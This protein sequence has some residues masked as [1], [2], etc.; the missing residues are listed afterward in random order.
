M[1]PMA[2][3]QIF[4]SFSWNPVTRDRITLLTSIVTLII[5]MPI[6]SNL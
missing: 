2:W 5:I 3:H 6:G 4:S 1:M